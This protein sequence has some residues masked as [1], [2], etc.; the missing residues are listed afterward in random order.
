LGTPD[1]VRRKIQ[2][3]IDAGA[4]KFVMRPYGPKETHV[5]QV[6]TLAKEVIAALQTP[7]SDVERIERLG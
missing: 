3:Y 5:E 6:H 4:T 7:F 2:D 1:Q